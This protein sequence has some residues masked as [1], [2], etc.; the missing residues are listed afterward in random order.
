[1]RNVTVAAIQMSIPETPEKSVEKAEKLVRKAAAEGA[2]VILRRSFSKT[3]ISARSA[4][5]TAIN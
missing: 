3:G 4:A 2:N 5:M 1:M